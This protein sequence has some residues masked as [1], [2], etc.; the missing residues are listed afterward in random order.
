MKDVIMPPKRS[1][2][3]DMTMAEFKGSVLA[4][5]QQIQGDISEVK[6]SFNGYCEKT[7]VRIGLLETWK[8]DVMAKVA[9]VV[10]IFTLGINL[11]WDSIKEKYFKG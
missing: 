6:T 7:N 10:A 5:L 1:N 2:E 8:T 3:F 11:L 9:V 4:Q